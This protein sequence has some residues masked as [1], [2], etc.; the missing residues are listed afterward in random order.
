[1]KTYTT[2]FVRWFGSFLTTSFWVSLV[3]GGWTL[4]W[5]LLDKDK[6][7]LYAGFA[8][9][10]GVGML[11]VMAGLTL[12]R[13]R[14]EIGALEIVLHQ[15]FL[16][17]T[18]TTLP[19]VTLSPIEVSSGPLMRLFGLADL[20]LAGTKIYGIPQ[21]HDLKAFLTARREALR[22]AARSGEMDVAQGTAELV[23]ERLAKAIER[24]ERRLPSGSA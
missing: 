18:T 20:T 6:P 23:Q 17:R 15:G 7:D 21:A 5:S 12:L 24:L 11:F 22:E 9:I 10:G 14:Y 3:G 16:W 19:I 13:N 8:L 4:L 2:P 1:M